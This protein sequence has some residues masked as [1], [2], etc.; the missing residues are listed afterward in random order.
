MRN[1][2]H[3]SLPLV[4]K[5]RWHGE[6]VTEGMRRVYIIPHLRGRA[7]CKSATF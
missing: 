4:T 1:G 7:L 3:P 5:G 2:T 6:A